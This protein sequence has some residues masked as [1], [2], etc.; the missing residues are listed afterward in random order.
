MPDARATRSWRRSTARSVLDPRSYFAR[1]MKALALQDLL[2]DV[3]AA[4]SRRAKP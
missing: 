3:R 2:G 4:A 1:A